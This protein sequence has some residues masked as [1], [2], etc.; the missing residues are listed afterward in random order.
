MVRA[1]SSTSKV[2]RF[3]PLNVDLAAGLVV[4]SKLISGVREPADDSLSDCS[5]P[6][7]RFCRDA[8]DYVQAFP[9]VHFHSMSPCSQKRVRQLTAAARPRNYR[10]RGRKKRT[11]PRA[12]VLHGNTP[13]ASL[14]HLVIVGGRE[15]KFTIRS[16]NDPAPIVRVAGLT[17][18]AARRAVQ[19]EPIG[20]EPSQGKRSTGDRRRL[21]VPT[22]PH[23]AIGPT[24]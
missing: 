14:A 12:Q 18:T 15:L 19:V 8:V 24:L 17:S 16:W 6:V 1:R 11:A 21:V 23:G 10:E 7:P 20:R 22:G 9:R 5:G 3:G 13:A 4:A 2:F